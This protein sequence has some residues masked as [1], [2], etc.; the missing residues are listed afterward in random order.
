MFGVSRNQRK[1]VVQ[2]GGS[3][4]PVN[5]RQRRSPRSRTT[6]ESSPAVRD[7]LIDREDAV[8]EPKRQVRSSQASS[9]VRR[10][11]SGREVILLR[12]SPSVR[13]LR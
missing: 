7:R 12:I 10:L 6:R 9:A 8:R 4:K 5:N 3:E 11:A 2:G 1:V 13:T